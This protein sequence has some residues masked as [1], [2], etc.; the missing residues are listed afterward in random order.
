MALALGIEHAE[1]MAAEPV[2]VTVAARNAA[3]A[4]HDGDLV[5]GFGQQGPE[6]P[7]VAAAA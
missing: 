4:H 1:G 7:V 3:F 5:K 2:H 6:I